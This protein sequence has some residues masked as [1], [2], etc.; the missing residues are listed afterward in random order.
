VRLEWQTREGVPLL[1]ARAEGA[2]IAFTTRRGGVSSGSFASLNL[3]FATADDPARVAENRRRALAAS[4]ADSARAVSLRQRHGSDVIEA[5][6]PAPGAYLDASA[7]WP[8]GDGLVTSEPGLPLV[9][10]GA[11]CLTA[12][13]V[14]PGGRR[15]AVVHAGWRGLLAGVLEAAAERVGPDF[16]G[17]IGP[18]AGGCCY[19]VGDDVADQL[20]A[21]FG[22]DV[23]VQ[24]RADL[25]ACARRALERGGA[26]AVVSAGLCTICDSQRFHSHR[27]DGQGSGRQG[28]VA[29]L[30]A[31]RA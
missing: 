22:D 24:G 2:A 30:E 4:G 9:A 26:A 11:D 20:R 19:G 15:L 13:L 17:A 3:G 16:T 23:V 29:Y 28:V 12:A 25:A 27:R 7:A 10:L 31:E 5:E 18:G 21:R 6:H 1:L 8:E 14:A